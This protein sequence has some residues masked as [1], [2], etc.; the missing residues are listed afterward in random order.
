MLLVEAG[1]LDEVVEFPLL[2][3]ALVLMEI[4]KKQFSLDLGLSTTS[5]YVI[6]MIR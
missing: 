3:E 1:G 6:S 4:A 2:P 5:G